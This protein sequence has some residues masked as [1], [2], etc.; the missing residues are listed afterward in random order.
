MPKA[1]ERAGEQIEEQVLGTQ[2][3]QVTRRALKRFIGG[4]W[5]C[6]FCDRSMTLRDHQVCTGCGA[7]YGEADGAHYAVKTVITTRPPVEVPA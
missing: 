6:P 3:A 7:T 4:V 5:W 2:I 1:K